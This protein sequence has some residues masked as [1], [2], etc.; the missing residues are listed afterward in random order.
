MN[1]WHE[2]NRTPLITVA[3]ACYNVEK[4]LTRCITSILDQT[5]GRLEVILIDDGSHDRT[6]QICDYFAER[7]DR[8]RVVH[9]DNGGLSDARNRGMGLGTGEFIAFVDGDDYLEPRM[10]EYLLSALVRTDSDAAICSYYQDADDIG[11]STH[12]GSRPEEA[13]TLSN[14]TE[15]APLYRNND[16]E[17]KAYILERDELLTVYIEERD[18]MP[19]QNAAW[20]KLYR[21]ELFDGLL[22]PNQRYYEDMVIQTKVLSR[23]RRAVFVDTPLYHYIIGREGSIMAG[24]LREEIL[25]EQIP[26]YREKD[27]YL[28]SIGRKDLEDIHDYLVYKKLLL[29]YTQARRDKTGEKKRFKK[30]LEKELKNLSRDLERISKTPVSDPHQLFRMKLFLIN[31]WLFD[32][33][34]DINEGVILPA[35]YRL[36]GRKNDSDPDA[37]GSG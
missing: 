14:I 32:R 10:Y 6:G 33:F 20:N 16:P 22:F 28:R 34:T 13:G 12:Q 35:R 1:M 27:R 3:V 37:G 24:G 25:T 36:R 7:D 18:E 19:I 30:P 23:C 21:R 5:Y 26:S 8:V 17:P 9:Q 4:Y 31:P 29:L 11:K 15:Q 2:N